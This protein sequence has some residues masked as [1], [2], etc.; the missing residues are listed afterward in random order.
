MNHTTNATPSTP[1]RMFPGVDGA[2]SKETEKVM[3]NAIR[4]S[5]LGLFALVLIAGATK[6]DGIEVLQGIEVLGI[7]VL[8]CGAEQVV[9]HAD[10]E[11]GAIM[12]AF[13]H[14]GNPCGMTQVCASG[15]ASFN[16]PCSSPANRI[17]LMT[18]NGIEVL[19]VHSGLEIWE[20][21]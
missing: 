2:R 17:E 14:A 8:H 21:D 12:M 10:A 9:V 7:E 16:F 11:I 20:L 4:N 1:N 6:A 18:S 19:F 3:T 5:L 13:D 15:F